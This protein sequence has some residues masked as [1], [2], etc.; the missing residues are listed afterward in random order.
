[1]K[2]FSLR[3]KKGEGV[4]LLNSP[5][6]DWDI[7]NELDSKLGLGVSNDI[8]TIAPFVPLGPIEL[9]NILVQQVQNP[10]TNY[11]SKKI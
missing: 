5:S 1:M 10:V 11:L 2:S 7:Q 4:A 6:L 9:K 8:T 3:C